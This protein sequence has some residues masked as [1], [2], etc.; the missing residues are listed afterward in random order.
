MR[1]C[2][3]TCADISDQDQAYELCEASAPESRKR[4]NWS[5]ISAPSSGA[6]SAVLM[7]QCVYSIAV[8][9]AVAV[10]WPMRGRLQRVPNTRMRFCQRWAG[11]A[12][13]THMRTCRLACSKHK[14]P[15]QGMFFYNHLDVMHWL[16][17][18]DQAVSVIL[19]GLCS[20]HLSKTQHIRGC[21]I[22]ACIA[23]CARN[24]TAEI[25]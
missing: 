23:V 16:C 7:T 11:P 19:A 5:S 2:G 3:Q 18:L 8:S 10:R 12:Q 17:K 25:H 22:A 14:Q 4:Q 21:A 9:C 24:V 15:L 20:M 1:Q 13:R 6:S